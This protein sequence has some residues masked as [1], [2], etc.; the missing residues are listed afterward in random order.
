MNEHRTHT[1]HHDAERW[2]GLILRLGVWVSA[3]LMIFGLFL[4]AVSPSSIVMPSTNP[5]LGALA[6][7]LVSTSFDPVV[8][9]YT[10]LVILMLTPVIRVLT[11]V[12]GFTLERDWRFVF[13]S[14]LVLVLLVGEIFYSIFVKG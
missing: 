13:V 1:T 2:T 4:A 10:G 3:C 12:F 9:M 5:T 6:E 14:S 8:L 11:A 7:H